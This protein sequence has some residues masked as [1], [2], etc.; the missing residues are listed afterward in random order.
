MTNTTRH[1]EFK[2][3]KSSKFWEIAQTGESVTVRYGKTGTTGQSQ[4]KAFTDSGAANKHAR[5]LIAEKIGKG[6]AEGS[7]VT[8]DVETKG[9]SDK[10]SI[11]PIMQPVVGPE[12]DH[13]ANLDKSSKKAQKI[14]IQDKPTPLAPKLKSKIEAHL[15]AKVRLQEFF[16]L[17]PELM[18]GRDRM[19]ACLR[20]SEPSYQLLAEEVS[21]S[22]LDRTKS[23]IGRHLFISEQHP[24]PLGS[25]G[26]PI[27]GASMEVIGKT[28]PGTK[29]FPV[30]QLDMSWVN[31]MC[32]RD[33]EPCLL[34]FWL[35]APYFISGIVRKVPL[36]DLDTSR[37]LPIELDADVYKEGCLAIGSEDQNE[38]L[39]ASE[40]HWVV[41]PAPAEQASLQIIECRPMGVT[42]PDIEDFVLEWLKE[43]PNAE[44]VSDDIWKDLQ[45]FT[46][47]A[48][49]PSTLRSKHRSVLRLFGNFI[50]SSNDDPESFEGDGSLFSLDRGSRA[51]T[52]ITYQAKDKKT[53]ESIFLYNGK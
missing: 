37:M 20:F 18:E 28:P 3:D 36:S 27:W 39:S 17:H 9:D 11:G 8:K 12:N 33:F 7:T 41:V 38:L 29:M 34:Q 16:R 44:I 14:K 15:A 19:L 40:K 6:Y 21:L 26:E 25:G 35:E 5:K 47:D 48:L 10:T 43:D 46:W 45:L 24:H 50:M 32:G 42:G 1:F 53:G 30:L 52:V 13:P 23:L 31:Q 4:T 49:Q 22:N 51:S 2:D